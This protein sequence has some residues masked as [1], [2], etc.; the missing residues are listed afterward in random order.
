MS[1]SGDMTGIAGTW[2]IGKKVSLDETQQSKD[3]SFRLAFSTA[4]KAP[5]G[6]QISFEKNRIFIRWLKEQGFNIK[7]VTSD[8]YQ[9]YDLQQQL[10]AEGFNCS[11]LS[12]DRVADGICK[13]YQY[14]RSTIYE[15]RLSM[16]KSNRLFDEF[17]DIERNMATG[18]IDHTPNGHKDTLDAVCG[19]IYTASSHAEEFAFDYGESLETT[20][21]SNAEAGSMQ[22]MQ[23]IA[24]DFEQEMQKLLD[25]M[26]KQE[27]TT[28]TTIQSNSVP[29]TNLYL[30]DGILVW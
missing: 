5:K 2:I 16:Y 1:V 26:Q 8:T 24:I 27:T 21:A 23:Q 17:I 4:I 11:I 9:S 18:K 19:S 20:I 13:P 30:M 14:L 10:T 15:R 29:N 3:L 22:T 28:R 7:E 12:V 6:R 25:P